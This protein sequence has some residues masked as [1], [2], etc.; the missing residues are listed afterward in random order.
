MIRQKFKST[1]RLRQDMSSTFIT[2]YNSL[3]G[4]L[5]RL[6]KKPMREKNLQ[7]NKAYVRQIT[8]KI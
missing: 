2:V 7:A 6:I 5:L 3:P 8:L 1:K 4:L